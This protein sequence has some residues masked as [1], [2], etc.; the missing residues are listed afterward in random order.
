DA[1]YIAAVAIVLVTWAAVVPIVVCIWK[2]V[3]T[4]LAGRVFTIDAAIWLHRI[5]ITAMVAIGLGV[6][7]R[8]MVASVI[9]MRPGPVPARGFPERWRP[10]FALLL[11]DFA[12][13]ARRASASGMGVTSGVAS[14][15][16]TRASGI[17]VATGSAGVDGTNSSRSMRRIGST[18]ATTFSSTTSL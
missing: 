15:S 12:C 10:R 4:Y 13:L 5:G 11:P 3:G 14:I 18:I 7:A 8:P 9:L 17:S 2:L 16:G 6:V 1:R